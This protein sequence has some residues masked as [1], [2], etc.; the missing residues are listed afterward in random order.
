MY[1]SYEKKYSEIFPFLFYPRSLMS[2]LHLTFTYLI[3]L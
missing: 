2:S 1:M 3:P